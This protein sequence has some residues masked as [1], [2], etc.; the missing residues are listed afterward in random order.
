VIKAKPRLDPRPFLSGGRSIRFAVGAIFHGRASKTQAGRCASVSV[1]AGKHADGGGLW[2]VKREDGGGK[3][4]YRYTIRGKRREMGLGSIRFV[5]LN[6]ARSEWGFTG[7][8]CEV[9]S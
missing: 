5:P 2:L 8:R 4:I 6:K 3:W 1:P 9:R 7:F